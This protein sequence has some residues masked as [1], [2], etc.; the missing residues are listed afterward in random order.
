MV[1][2]VRVYVC[3]A[4]L[5]AEPAG[6][7]EL[8]R[9]VTAEFTDADVSGFVGRQGSFEIEINGKLIFSKMET[10]GFP[11]ED[12]IMDAIQRAYDGQPVE[13]ITKSQPPCVIL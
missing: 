9:A 11:Y 2:K 8:K 6:L 12:D 1:G 10:S 5:E 4:P 7:E 3:E 13:K